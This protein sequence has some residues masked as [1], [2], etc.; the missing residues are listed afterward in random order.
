MR[1]KTDAK[2]K[3]LWTCPQCQRKFAKANQWH[4]CG[5][6]KRPPNP[7]CGSKSSFLEGRFE[8]TTQLSWMACCWKFWNP[9]RRMRIWASWSRGF[10]PRS[11]NYV[12]KSRAC[13]GRIWNCGSRPAIGEVGTRM[14]SNESRRW[15]KRMNNSAVRFASCRPNA[16]G[17]VRSSS[18]VATA[19]IIWTIPQTLRASGNAGDN[20]V[21]LLPNAAITATYL[22]GNKLLT[23]HHRLSR[24]CYRVWQPD[25]RCESDRNGAGWQPLVHGA[26]R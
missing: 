21:S 11:T 7:F 9:F 16:L 14:P 2:P 13:V 19:A 6:F 3:P 10:W 15:N 1:T 26:D 5:K 25:R 12:R 17:G 18:H 8:G 23:C 20:P 4:S 24:R 22:F